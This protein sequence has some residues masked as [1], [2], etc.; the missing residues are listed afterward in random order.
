VEPW[1][2]LLDDEPAKPV[3]EPPVAP[4]AYERE[5]RRSFVDEFLADVPPPR[6]SVEPIGFAHNGFHIDK[7]ARFQPLSRFET[8]DEPKK[9]DI[10]SS[11]YPLDFGDH[12]R[13]ESRDER[14]D[15]ES[16]YDL[17]DERPSGRHSRGRHSRD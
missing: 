5:S 13:H 1:H 11:D 16:S 9:P 2:S 6:P 10:L 15:F 17:H 12:S 4:P 8:T 14:Y 3:S 7:Q